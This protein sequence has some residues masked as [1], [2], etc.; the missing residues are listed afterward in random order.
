MID[1]PS[2]GPNP[3]LQLEQKIVV[4]TRNGLTISSRVRQVFVNSS[5]A[6]FAKRASNVAADSLLVSGKGNEL[7]LSC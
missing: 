3:K 2:L 1:S 5:F 7:A 4:W 6:T